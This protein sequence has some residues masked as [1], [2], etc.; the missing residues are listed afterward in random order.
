MSTSPSSLPPNAL[1]RD[2]HFWEAAQRD[3][4][5][6]IVFSGMNF[7][8]AGLNLT[9]VRFYRPVRIID[10]TFHGNSVIHEVI[11]QKGL[12][13]QGCKFLGKS[14]F[15]G[16]TF[17]DSS[18]KLSEC[19]FLGPC[20][21]SIRNA[22]EVQI[23]SNFL[24]DLTIK[25]VAGT[26]CSLS[27]ANKARRIF[28]GTT[29]LQG[30]FRDLNLAHAELEEI[31][32]DGVTVA[33]LTSF[34]SSTILGDLAAQKSA[35]RGGLLFD[36]CTVAGEIR[37]RDCELPGL[38][39]FRGSAQLNGLVDFSA[40]VP[41]EIGGLILD[42]A[43]VIGVL[44]VS[45]RRF[46]MRTSFVETDFKVPPSFHGVALFPDTS[47]LDA[48]FPDDFSLHKKY[49][50]N[51]AENAYRSL[52]SACL[53]IEAHADEQRFFSYEMRARKVTESNKAIKNLFGLYEYLSDYGQSIY[54]PLRLLALLWALNL[55]IFTVI[56]VLSI[57]PAPSGCDCRVAF[58]SSRL[59]ELVALATHQTF[60]FVSGL[61][62]LT[63]PETLKQV[64]T[65][66]ALSMLY[67][68][69]SLASSAL[70]ITFLFLLGLGLR[71]K[72]RLR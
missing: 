63:S 25:V 68:F 10:C 45:N 51:S 16:L 20:G 60:P 69:W 1:Q 57:Y 42:N 11:F 33:S 22:S 49:S 15:I 47:F 38:I 58:S 28:K 19:E 21:L 18:I 62:D 40:S 41:T 70:S 5:D 14:D 4:P 13:L 54:K 27:S 50:A 65:E 53:K 36:K 71:N 59:A 9:E 37:M 26:N 46:T 31:V 12:E 35:F 66:S 44:D 17:D 56:Q 55:T 52:R 3:H 32:L 43:E 23:N 7:S 64:R 72:F 29:R 61:R 6:D 2:R 30:A 8:D 67:S 39:S 34:E 24:A 48:K